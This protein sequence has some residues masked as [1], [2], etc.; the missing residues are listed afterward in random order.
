M[1]V[2]LATGTARQGTGT[3]RQGP[4]D[5][6]PPRASADAA[7]PPGFTR[8]RGP[9]RVNEQ[10]LVRQETLVRRDALV[11]AGPGDV[12]L[13]ILDATDLPRGS[14]HARPSDRA[15]AAIRGQSF[16]T[17][18]PP[19]NAVV[20]SSPVHVSTRVMP[21]VI[22]VETGRLLAPLSPQPV[23]RSSLPSRSHCGGARGSYGST[24]SP[25]PAP[26]R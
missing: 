3:R 25:S 10:I 13:S 6:E 5:R 1:P 2:P 4:R 20:P 26:I 17:R 21:V 7:S 22:I 11:P 19:T 8:A 12:D 15:V 24:R 9:Q 23:N 16:G 18:L 14:L